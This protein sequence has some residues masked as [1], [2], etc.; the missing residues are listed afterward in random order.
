MR[1]YTTKE[2]AQAIGVGHQT[3]L[4]WLYAKKLAEPE[5]LILRGQSLRLWTKAGIKERPKVQGK[6]GIWQAQQKRHRAPEGTWIAGATFAIAITPG[7]EM[8]IS[9]P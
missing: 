2:V 1:R 4:G 3:L 7:S 6:R 5:R 9:C 8:E